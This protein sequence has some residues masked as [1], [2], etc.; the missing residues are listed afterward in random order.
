MALDALVRDFLAWRKQ[1]DDPGGQGALAGAYLASIASFLA[2]W[3][4]RAALTAALAPLLRGVRDDGYWIGVK[5]A[6][7]A[8][9]GSGSVNWG[10][11]RPGTP[12][13]VTRSLI[14]ALDYAPGYRTLTATVDEGA[15][16]AAATRIRALAEQLALAAR[17]GDTADQIT[18][19]VRAN[20]EDP[21]RAYRIALTELVKAQSAATIATYQRAGVRE[22]V[23]ASVEDAKV[24]PA[25]DA[26]AAAGPVQVGMPFPSG[27]AAPPIHPNDRCALLPAGSP[28]LP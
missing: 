25:C 14:D 19:L 16:S 10:G 6:A 15:D 5:A 28:S 12:A 23:W 7:A 13:G 27:D 9:D 21:P 2:A 17:R 22:H 18:Q 4:A 3:G 1:H 8:V 26:N 11:W 24:C 20:L